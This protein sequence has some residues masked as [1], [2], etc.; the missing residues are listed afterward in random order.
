LSPFFETY[1][2][3][4]DIPKVKVNRKGRDRYDISLKGV[5]LSLPV[6][7]LTTNG[8]EKILIS[9]TPVRVKSDDMVVID[10]NGWY[11]LDK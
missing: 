3:S 10:P 8:I 11:L 7:V 9:N 6:E 2:Y 5:G 4:T 1:L